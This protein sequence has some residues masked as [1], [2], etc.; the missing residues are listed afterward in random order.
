VVEPGAAPPAL[1]DAVRAA[2]KQIRFDHAEALPGLQVAFYRDARRR[3]F[4]PATFDLQ[5]AAAR[6]GAQGWLALNVCMLT[7]GEVLFC[8]LPRQL[9]LSHLPY[10]CIDVTHGQ[11]RADSV[12]VPFRTLQAA[13]GSGGTCYYSRR[14][15]KLRAGGQE[16]IVAFSRHA[17]ERICDR[18]VR[19]WLTFRGSGDV[20]GF[21]DN[22]V[23]F[24]DCSD[25]CGQPCFTFYNLCMP[26]F[27]THGYA[28]G[29]L[30]ELDPGR[31]Y[32]YRV[33]YCPAVVEA[34]FLK[35][36]TLL[37]PGMRGTPEYEAV[38]RSSLPR[39]VRD[40]MLKDVERLTL[41]ELSKS[42]DYGLL[43]W[44]H[45][46]GVPQVVPLDHQVFRY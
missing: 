33:G 41:A 7:L 38:S 42:G 36:K 44:F 27:V 46:N 3:G 12:L 23:Y 17:V 18:T 16:L 26:G 24:E 21:L 10:V 28:T 9:L 2:A 8:R 40:R 6:T 20:F 37:I 35:A 4:G 45:T 19:Q 13:K 34:G 14:R 22:C 31:A 43:R 5:L 25:A 32:Y 29:V 39:H 11:P 1:V 30:D 15:P